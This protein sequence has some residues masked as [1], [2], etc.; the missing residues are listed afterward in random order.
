MAERL[1]T[2]VFPFAGVELRITRRDVGTDTQAQSVDGNDSDESDEPFVDPHFFDPDYTVAATTG[3]CRVWEGAEVL[4]EMLKLDDPK[5]PSLKNKKVLELGSGVGLVG[6]AAASKGAHVML[7]DLRQVVDEVLLRN[8]C[9]NAARG[10]AGG[11]Y[12]DAST[13]TPVKDESSPASNAWLG[14][15]P[16]I[17]GNGGTATAQP[18]DWCYGLDEQI[19]SRKTF[20]ES[21]LQ[22]RDDE[23]RCGDLSSAAFWEKRAGTPVSDPR[24]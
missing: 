1:A 18:L 7:T 9:E 13:S 11:S 5:L 23:L 14:S 15:L 2:D 19:K 10:H 20:H 4:C 24:R 17:G 21:A 16:I 8:I 6:I 3:F 22:R 12:A